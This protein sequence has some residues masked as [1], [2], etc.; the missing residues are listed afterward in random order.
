MKDYQSAPRVACHPERS[1]GSRK[2]WLIFIET[3]VTQTSN[4]RS[5][6]PLGMTALSF[7][8]GGHEQ[9]KSHHHKSIARV[10][11]VRIG[12]RLLLTGYPAFG[13]S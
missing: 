4:A 3:S 11:S 10:I 1:E 6:A 2:S 8:D 5:L 7:R 12:Q 9:K 13:Q